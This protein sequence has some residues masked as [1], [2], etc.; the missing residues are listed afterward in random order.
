M[1]M[2]ELGFWSNPDRFVGVI[3][4]FIH[5]SIHTPP[6]NTSTIHSVAWDLVGHD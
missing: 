1:S 2:M 4:A 6:P 5:S 3:Q